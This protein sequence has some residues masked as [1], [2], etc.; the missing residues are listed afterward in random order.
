MAKEEILIDNGIMLSIC[1]LKR[2]RIIHMGNLDEI[3][4]DV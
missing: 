1:Q 3:Q 4:F 2:T